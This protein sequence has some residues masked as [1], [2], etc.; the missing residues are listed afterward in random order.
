MILP[1]LFEPAH[2]LAHQLRR[3]VQIPLGIRDRGKVT[4]SAGSARGPVRNGTTVKAYSSQIRASCRADVGRDCRLRHA[5]RSAGT[6]HRSVGESRHYQDD[7]P[8][9]TRTSRRI[10]VAPPNDVCVLQYSL[11]ALCRSRRALGRVGTCRYAA[12]LTMFE[13]EAQHGVICESHRPSIGMVG[14]LRRKRQRT[15]C[16]N[17]CAWVGR[18][19]MTCKLAHDTEASRPV[20]GLDV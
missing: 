13:S 9:W 15:R 16:R 3:G 4:G 7:C 18:T 12:S 17:L 2:R 8:G 6:T 1:A 19:T 20:R 14:P 5:D 11:R 10:P